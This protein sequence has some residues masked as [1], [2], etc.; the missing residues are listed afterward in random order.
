[1][2]TVRSIDPSEKLKYSISII[3]TEQISWLTQSDKLDLPEILRKKDEVA[4]GKN[5]TWVWLNWCMKINAVS[6]L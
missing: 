6:L 3:S 2:T 1:M 5:C 4:Q